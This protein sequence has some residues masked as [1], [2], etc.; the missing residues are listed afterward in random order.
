[1]ISKLALDHYNMTPDFKQRY[2]VWTGARELTLKRQLEHKT[3]FTREQLAE[4][5]G[6]DINIVNHWI[7][8]LMDKG[9]ITE[10]NSR[11]LIVK[12]EHLIGIS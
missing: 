9:Y 7:Q 10:N 12:P 2:T 11:K 8:I 5:V 6:F 4:Y 1:M 3:G